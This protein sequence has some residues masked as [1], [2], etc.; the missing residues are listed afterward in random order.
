[1]ALLREEIDSVIESDGWSKAS[2][3][4]MK[5]LDSFLRESSRL[6]AITLST[7]TSYGPKNY[8]LHIVIF[9]VM[10]AS[11]NRYALRDYTF[12]DGTFIPKGAFVTASLYSLHM[13]DDNYEDASKFDPWRFVSK[14]ES[15]EEG[16]S[17]KH[18]FTNTSVEYLAFGL[19]KHAWYV[20]SVNCIQGIPLTWF[21]RDMH[22]IQSWTVLR[23]ERDQGNDVLSRAELR[24]QASGWRYR[25]SCE[26]VLWDVCTT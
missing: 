7:S 24:C 12:Q 5:R 20:T 6:N 10:P 8:D 9:R 3:Q 17:V 15:G 1:M 23:S 19:G 11:L 16:E 13:D 18:Q 21:E 22:Y 2:M 14:R 26:S 4:K 25:A